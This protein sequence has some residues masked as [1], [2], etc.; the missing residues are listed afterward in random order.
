MRKIFYTLVI[1]MVMVSSVWGVD[2]ESGGGGNIVDEAFSAANFNGGTTSGVSQDDFYD[3][4]HGIDTNDDGDI[5]A[6]DATVWA[7]KAPVASPTFTGIITVPAGSVTAPSI[8]SDDADS[9]FY[10]GSK[11]FYWSVDGVN[12]FGLSSVGGLNTTSVY[13]ANYY[14]TG[15]GIG[16][17]LTGYIGAQSTHAIIG[18][19]GF[20]L[21]GGNG[22]SQGFLKLS[23]TYN[24][25]G[26]AAAT[27]FLINRTETAVGSG[28]QLFTDLQVASVSKYSITNKGIP[29][30]SAMDYAGTPVAPARSTKTFL[31]TAALAADGDDACGTTADCLTLPIPTTMGYLEMWTDG[32]LYLSAV[33]VNAGTATAITDSDAAGVGVEYQAAIASCTGLCLHDGGTN[34]IIFND[35]AGAVTVT[36]RFVYD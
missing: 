8:V 1:C 4:W 15:S 17:T 6:L 5:D 12:K 34:A 26:S 27:D 35:T 25:T 20:S 22:T 29:Q 11:G 9:G 3:L 23:G 28:A 7:T 2:M 18:T 33:V 32:S 21:S 30:F 16:V 24:Q 36:V 10:F 13:A 19:N 14:A 31:H